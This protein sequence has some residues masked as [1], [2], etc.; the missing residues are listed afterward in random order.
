M[1]SHKKAIKGLGRYLY[2]TKK[3]GIIYNPDTS[4]GL[5]CYVDPYFA[6]GLQQADA[7]DPENVMSRT[8]IVIMYANCP[9]FWRS[10]LQTEIDLSTAETE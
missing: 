10:S 9:T 3:K 5:E 6:G 2:H 8:G 1:L 7:D 4:K